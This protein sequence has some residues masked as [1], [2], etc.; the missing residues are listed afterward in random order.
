MAK[1]KKSSVPPASTILAIKRPAPPTTDQPVGNDAP[2]PPPLP[3]EESSEAAKH[4]PEPQVTEP[5]PKFPPLVTLPSTTNA[6][7][8]VF[9]P[10]DQILVRA[11]WGGRVLTEISLIYEG[12]EVAWV[13]YKPIEPLREGWQWEGGVMMAAQL[14]KK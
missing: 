2:S 1:K 12:A 4:T 5:K 9:Q 13:Q 3:K 11:P 14:V 8:E 7:G 6:V 10:G